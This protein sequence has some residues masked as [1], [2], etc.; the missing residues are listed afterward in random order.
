MY[1][2]ERVTMIKRI[3]DDGELVPDVESDFFVKFT[4]TGDPVFDYDFRAKEYSTKEEAEQVIDKLKPL[5]DNSKNRFIRHY[6]TIQEV[7]A[8]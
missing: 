6:L 2:I 8:A 1:K 5:Y 4:K 7:R 3:D